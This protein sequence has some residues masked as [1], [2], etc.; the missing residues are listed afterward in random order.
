MA[1]GESYTTAHRLGAEVRN[2]DINE[3][4][5]IH[6]IY[7]DA[8]GVWY[9]MATRNGMSLGWWHE[10]DIESAPRTRPASESRQSKSAQAA[11]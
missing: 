9:D 8:S 11:G 6:G 1:K 7:I 10:T 2:R 4:A 5:I 3:K